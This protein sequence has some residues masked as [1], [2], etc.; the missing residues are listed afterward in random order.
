MA[1]QPNGKRGTLLLN[2]YSAARSI[3]ARPS[4]AVQ[5]QRA[6]AALDQQ[7]AA[8]TMKIDAVLRNLGA[9]AGQVAKATTS[10]PAQPVGL[11]ELLQARLLKNK[12]VRE[13][14]V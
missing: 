9:P 13:G 14:K 3:A 4:A 7:L 5:A 2:Q 10:K 12:L 6:Q 8:A 1:T 11:G